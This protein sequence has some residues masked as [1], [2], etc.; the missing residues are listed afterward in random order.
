MRFLLS[1]LLMILFSF[2]AGLFLP[3]WGLAIICFAVALLV[4]QSPGRSFLAGFVSILVLWGLLAAWIDAANEHVLS[5][6]I[7]QLFKLGNA[8]I[9]LVLITALVGALVGGFAALSGSFLR[10]ARR[11]SHYA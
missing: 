2:I 4:R 9:L 7:A 8:P 11:R 6:K 5:G 1:V 3:W 10:P